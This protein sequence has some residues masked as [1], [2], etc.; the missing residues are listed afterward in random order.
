MIA[1]AQLTCVRIVG[2]GRR[3]NAKPDALP[4]YLRTA[5]VYADR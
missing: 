1:D 3:D 2:V 5:F 4:L